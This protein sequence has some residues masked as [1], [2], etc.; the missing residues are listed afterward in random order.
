M[1]VLIEKIDVSSKTNK[2]FSQKSI[3]KKALIKCNACIENK[4]VS[5][6]IKKQCKQYKSIYESID[7]LIKMCK[8]I[9]NLLL[10]S[11][12][13]QAEKDLYCLNI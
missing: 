2:Q 10:F 9:A 7:Q 5:Q 8:T 13:K 3:K 1:K 11:T 12:I 6:Q 4:L